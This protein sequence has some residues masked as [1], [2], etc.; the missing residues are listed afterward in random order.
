MSPS[1][2]GSDAGDGLHRGGLAAP[3]EPISVTSLAFAHLEVHAP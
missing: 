3:L 1:L 2:I